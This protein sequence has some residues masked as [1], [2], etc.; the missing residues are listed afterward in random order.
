MNIADDV[1]FTRETT[2]VRS[3]STICSFLSR[4]LV[5]EKRNELYQ[6]KKKLFLPSIILLVKQPLEI[7]VETVK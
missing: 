6:V 2:C 4:S 3:V 1:L 7:L 5:L